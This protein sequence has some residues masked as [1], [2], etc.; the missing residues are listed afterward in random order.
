MESLSFYIFGFTLGFF[1]LFGP[2]IFFIALTISLF[3]RGEA[4]RIENN[5]IKKPN[6]IAKGIVYI[7]LIFAT[8]L[9]IFNGIII[10][11]SD[12]LSGSIYYAG[13]DLT[14]IWILLS[15]IPLLISLINLKDKGLKY[16]KWIIICWILNSLVFF[17][18]IMNPIPQSV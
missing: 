9:T 1:I 16:K 8:I 12:T 18:G 13:W 14:L 10:A 15:W 17:T 5:F 7:H 11:F 2:T 3:N 6:P 4:Q